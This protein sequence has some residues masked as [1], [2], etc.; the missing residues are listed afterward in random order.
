ML[1]ENRRTSI[2]FN[3]SFDIGDTT[4]AVTRQTRFRRSL[5]QQVGK[6]NDRSTIRPVESLGVQSSSAVVRLLVSSVIPCLS[7]EGII[8]PPQVQTSRLT[9]INQAI[10]NL[11]MACAS[12]RWEILLP[13][14]GVSL[15]DASLSIRRNAIIRTT[16]P[17]K[18]TETIQRDSRSR[19]SVAYY[20]W[21]YSCCGI[22]VSV[23][24]NAKANGNASFLFS[25]RDSC[26]M[27]NNFS[28]EREFRRVS[29]SVR[30]DGHKRER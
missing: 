5:C 8:E 16:I 12:E 9:V 19:N 2:P 23:E 22:D 11:I 29:P 30:S 6:K 7:I 28:D 20:S 27:E 18:A 21:R 15:L 13:W 1:H 26:E 3:E 24:R 10:A 25:L 4:A 17:R 14:M